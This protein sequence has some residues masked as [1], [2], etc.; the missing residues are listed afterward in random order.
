MEAK[1]RKIEAER[2][3]PE[4]TNLADFD[5]FETLGTGTFGVVKLARH[6]ASGL[7]F[8]I[9]SMLKRK[10]IELRQ[11]DHV[12]S[13]RLVLSKIN[14]PFI[15]HLYG[16]FQDEMNVFLVLEYVQGGELFSHLQR[17][18]RFR[19]EVARFYAAEVTLALIH[20]HDKGIIYRDLKPENI[21]LDAHGH[22]KITD[23][24]FAKTVEELT[25]TLC[26][27]ADTIVLLAVGDELPVSEIRTGDELVG[28]DGAPRRVLRT[29]S[30][31][32]RLY[33]LRRAR[34]PGDEED[35]GVLLQCTADH[36]LPL[37]Y[38]PATRVEEDARGLWVL[39]R[40]TLI[41]GPPDSVTGATPTRFDAR[42][43]AVREF[44]TQEEATAWAAAHRGETRLQ[45][46]AEDFGR[47][48]PELQ[49]CCFLI[50]R[51]APGAETLSEVPFVLDAPP[52]S[53]PEQP[54]VGFTVDGDGL[55]LL[56]GGLVAH[57][58]GTHEYLAPEI[59]R[60]SG[61]DKA[62]DWWAL[63]ILIFEMLDGDPP[64]C[65]EDTNEVYKQ[66]LMEEPRFPRHFNP[67]TTDLIRRLLTKESARRL[68]AAPHTGSADVMR[69]KFFDPINWEEFAERRV[70]APILPIV[71][72]PADTRNFDPYDEEEEEEGMEYPP[73]VLANLAPV[74]KR[75]E[76]IDKMFEEF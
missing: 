3:L 37:R 7:Y 46:T 65:D 8:A 27:A 39:L 42:P 71:R 29:T 34:A 58:C 19:L 28:P 76:D 17:C 48:S 45:I 15:V 31:V 62:A 44:T 21:L 6:R 74:P 2:R 5:L 67:T 33:T 73:E 22:V 70:R 75:R 61:H 68:G 51:T 18:G 24:G 55:A 25:Y 40:R 72:G 66:I 30:G 43:R 64:F 16:T 63:G 12:N 35:G 60:N 53:A 56:R 69:H 10:L 50:A 4:C 32:A 23:F 36:V 47:L 59:I 57:N 1:R 49:A 38:L 54:F 11:V 9:K 13:E 26:L 41:V 52:P 20:L 14:S